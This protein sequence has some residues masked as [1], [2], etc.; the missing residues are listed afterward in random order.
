MK[1]SMMLDTA[2][3][4]K[5]R[6]L[7][8]ILLSYYSKERIR[9]AYLTLKELFAR[10]KIPFE[11]IVM[12]DGSKDDS[13]RMAL[14]LE[15]EFPNV[16]AYQLSR[17]YTSHYSIFAGLSQAAGSCAI[18]IADDEQLPYDNVVAMYRIWEQGEKIVI[19]HRVS[20][21]DSWRS[22]IFSEC[23]YRIMNTLSDV[24]YPP[25]GADQFLIDREVIDIINSRIHPINTTSI[26]EVLRL[27][28]SPYF[29]G[30]DRPVGLNKNKSRWSF[31][32]K[33]RL[34][35]D[36]FF[37]SSSFPILLINRIGFLSA[38]LAGVLIVFYLYIAL[39]GNHK[40]WGID[41]PGWISIILFIMLFGGMIMLSLGVIAEY[42]WRIYEEVKA[43]PGYIIRKKE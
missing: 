32:K 17:N 33:L 3:D 24:Q 27:G 13:Y 21:D 29:Y 16:R 37:S 43:R 38:S 7:S 11:F 35:K 36:T 15:K 9:K 14:E 41:V 20:R 5:D 19:P 30:Y 1:G 8:V 18:S 34:A 42:I 12:D 28:F 40:F 31:R 26:S 25:G 22:W 4:K 23:F 2:T 10:E 39:F 6:T